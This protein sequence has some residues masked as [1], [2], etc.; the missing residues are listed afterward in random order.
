MEIIT[1]LSFLIPIFI[2]KL[3]RIYIPVFVGEILTGMAI[4]KS[5]I[6]IIVMDEWLQFM[7]RVHFFGWS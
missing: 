7:K 2:S 3:K 5:G 1:I 4:G 6:N